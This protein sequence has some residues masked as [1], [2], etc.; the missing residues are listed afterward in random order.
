M[1]AEVKR[2]KRRVVLVALAACLVV[3]GI[4]GT[5]AWFSAQSSLTN[6][7]K[8]GNITDPT[9][10][11]D[12]PSENLPSDTTKVSGNIYEPSW[13]DQSAIAPGASVVRIRTWASARTASLP[14]C[15]CT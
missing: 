7:F 11:P 9:T 2:R 10:K 1:E 5:L 13:V 8:V 6:T 12:K 4:G 3:A 15:T 14:M